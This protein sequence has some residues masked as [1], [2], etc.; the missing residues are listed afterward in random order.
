V[1]YFSYLGSMVTNDARCTREIKFRIAMAKA[2]N[3]NEEEE[4]ALFTGKLDLN[5][6]KKRVKCCIWSV[7]L[8]GAETWILGK[9]DHKYLESCEMWCWRRMEKV[10]WIDRVR[11][12][13]V[14]QRV[15]ED[16]N[17]LHIVKT[18]KVNWIGH[19]LSGNCFLKQVME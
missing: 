11:S 9:A 2:L 13:E 17:I 7:A 8:C 18:R 6:R 4:E 5:L 1:E 3:N 10:G 14:L 15:R 16:R 19:I 12:E